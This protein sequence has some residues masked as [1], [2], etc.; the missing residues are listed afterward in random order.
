MT[1][2]CTKCATKGCRASLPCDDRSGE[3]LENYLSKDVLKCTR[4]ASELIDNGRAGSLSRIQEIVEYSKLRGYSRVGVAY[5]YGMEKE[6]VLLRKY[7]K[8][9]GLHPVM[10][11]CTVDGIKE[12]QIDP[13][14]TDE[15][16]SCNPLGQAN[17]LNSSGVK[18]TVLMGLCLGHDILLQKNLKMDFTTLIVKDRVNNHNPLQGIPGAKGVEDYFIENMPHNFH[19]I[20][21]DELKSKINTPN[22]LDGVYLLDLRGHKAFEKDGIKGSI[23]CLLSDL[24]KKHMELM[25]EKTNEI[26]VYCNGGIQS[27]YVVMF[28]AMKGYTNVKSLS[29]GF[30]RFIGSLN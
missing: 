14:K 21:V 18:F 30:S 27:I 15:S 19:M 4:A 23:N 16:V 2:D 10:V 29:G 1:M 26:I 20:G 24:Q 9:E 17:V 28:L 8:H 25:P 7:L 5:C 11:S 22:G 3:Y 12:S 13:D 6:A